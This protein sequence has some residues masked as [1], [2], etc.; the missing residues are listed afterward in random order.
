MFP[1]KL[2]R[3]GRQGSLH[4]D[5]V[6][7]RFPL[8]IMTFYVCNIWRW[9]SMGRGG[10]LWCRLICLCTVAHFHSRRQGTRRTGP[11]A[12]T[13]LSISSPFILTANV[14]RLLYG[15]EFGGTLS[16][17]SKCGFGGEEF[18][19]MPEW[20]QGGKSVPVTSGIKCEWPRCK[21]PLHTRQKKKKMRPTWRA[22]TVVC[23]LAAVTNLLFSGGQQ[24]RRPL[25]HFCNPARPS[26]KA[27]IQLWHE[28]TALH[29]T[30][31]QPPT[32]TTSFNLTPT[33]LCSCCLN[34]FADVQFI[35][36]LWLL[37]FG[38]WETQLRQGGREEWGWGPRK[39]KTVNEISK[40]L[41]HVRSFWRSYYILS[42]AVRMC[43]IGLCTG[44][45]AWLRDLFSFVLPIYRCKRLHT[46][47]PPSPRPPAV[48]DMRLD[49]RVTLSDTVCA[50]LGSAEELINAPELR[51]F[52]DGA[53][54]SSLVS[55]LWRC[56]SVACWH[57]CDC[58]H[59][60]LQMD[61]C[62]SPFPVNHC[63]SLC[64]GHNAI[65]FTSHWT[66][67]IQ[68]TPYCVWYNSQFRSIFF[69]WTS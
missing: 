37:A 10:G 31:T 34:G 46:C 19:L 12:S 49:Q 60:V 68:V 14:L 11:G 38:C 67:G 62:S 53:A 52:E 7:Y 32:P 51:G 39:P 42:V 22:E 64:D 5:H 40:M 56:R 41:Q 18:L 66:E 13:L 23:R 30:T 2:T 33:W 1:G 44:V 15:Q 36:L 63:K 57:V 43:K 20:G 35:S 6:G 24:C 26:W 47:G 50:T 61:F 65:I 55:C 69:P 17:R 54:R 45:A 21:L 28:V 29:R 3:K 48:T 25:F 8:R 58:S 27:P 16:N 9:R 4:L 59:T